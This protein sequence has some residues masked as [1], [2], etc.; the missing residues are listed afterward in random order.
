[1]SDWCLIPHEQFVTYSL[2]RTSYSQWD[3]DHVPF[4][5]DRHALDFDGDFLE[6]TDMFTK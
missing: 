2:A 3:D 4:V 5:L 1:M 6:K